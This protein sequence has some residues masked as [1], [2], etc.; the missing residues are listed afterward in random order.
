MLDEGFAAAVASRRVV[1]RGAIYA[2]GPAVQPANVPSGRR[3]QGAGGLHEEKDELVALPA[4]GVVVI[5]RVVGY[6]ADAARVRPSLV[7]AACADAPDLANRM[8]QGAAEAV[9][10]ASPGEVSVRDRG[11]VGGRE[12]CEI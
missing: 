10:G 5:A 1:V 6:A 8:L 4:L 2:L 11:R 7:P 3:A 12:A 9:G